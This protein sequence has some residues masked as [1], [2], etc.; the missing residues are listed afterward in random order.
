MAPVPR[1]S[2]QTA[3][4]P[5]PCRA[6]S[7]PF[8]GTLCTPGDGGRHPALLLLAGAGA[9]NALRSAA[10]DLATHGYIAATVLYYGVPGTPPTL[11]EVPVEIAGRAIDALVARS[12]VDGGRIGVL[13]NSKGGEYALLLASTDP[14]IKAV[15]ANVPSPFAWYGLGQH[16]SP[17]GCSWSRSGKP[18]PCVAENSE[19]G[20]RIGEQFAAH[21]RIA[22]RAAYEAAAL[23]TPAVTAAFFPLERIAGPVLC[24]AA[25]DDQ[26][27]PSDTFCDQTMIYLRTHHHPFDDVSTTYPGAGHLF[28]YARGG[29]TYAMNA[30]GIGPATLLFGGTPVA[31]AQAAQQAWDQIYKFLDANLKPERSPRS[32]STVL[33]PK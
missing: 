9:G 31:D 13:G 26:M 30:I 24:L 3:D 15:V 2:T 32:E 8:V 21:A 22:L 1:E 18:L 4:D 25:G 12:D 16:S 7:T 27:W 23:N 17:T 33:R 5:G 20:R 14:R 11:V 10:A 29:P 19:A 6:V 28:I